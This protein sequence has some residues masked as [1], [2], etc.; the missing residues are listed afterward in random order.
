MVSCETSM[1]ADYRRCASTTAR[2]QSSKR[3]AGRSSCTSAAVAAVSVK[4]SRRNPSLTRDNAVP[5]T[6]PHPSVS[7]HPKDQRPPAK[8]TTGGGENPKRT[9]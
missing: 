1:F 7:D 9:S 5:T 2:S 4:S 3:T 8:D 6:Y